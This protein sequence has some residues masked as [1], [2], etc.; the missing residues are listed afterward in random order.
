MRRL[1]AIQWILVL[2]LLASAAPSFGQNRVFV[3]DGRFNGNLG[4]LAGGDAICQAE[5]DGQALGG[6]WVAWLSTV[7]PVVN[8]RDRLSPG[9]FALLNGSPVAASIADLTDGTIANAISLTPTGVI[10]MSTPVWTGTAPDGTPGAPPNDCGGWTGAGSGW[11]G[12]ATNSDSQWTFID[13]FPCDNSAPIYCFE[14]QVVPSLPAW[15][16][17]VLAVTLGAGSLLLLR[18]LRTGHEGR[19]A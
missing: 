16:L 8:A 17:L 14:R 18:H 19:L 5:A 2:A 15:A 4:G 13:T 12:N 7:S 9:S 10:L 11:F 1:R 6:V 3:T